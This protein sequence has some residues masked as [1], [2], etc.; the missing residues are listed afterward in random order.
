VE[1]EKE[2]EERPEIVRTFPNFTNYVNSP[3]IFDPTKLP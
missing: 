2:G 3:H 1:D